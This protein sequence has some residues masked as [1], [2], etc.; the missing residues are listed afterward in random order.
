MIMKKIIMNAAMLI[1]LVFAAPLMAQSQSLN[2]NE[3]N[4]YLTSSNDYPMAIEV[5][6]SYDYGYSQYY[7]VIPTFIEFGEDRLYIHYEITSYPGGSGNIEVSQSNWLGDVANIINNL[8]HVISANI[9][10]LFLE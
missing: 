2:E 6:I 9:H 8:P 10:P 7:Y 1:S 3:L 4:Q 5:I